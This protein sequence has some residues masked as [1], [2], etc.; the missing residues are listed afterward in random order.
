MPPEAVKPAAI[1]RNPAAFAP[2]TSLP[3]IQNAPP[4]GIFTLTKTHLKKTKHIHL[5]FA[6]F[7]GW[8]KETVPQMAGCHG[9]G[10]ESLKKTI[11]MYIGKYPK[12]PDMS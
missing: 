4:S 10:F 9:D 2:Q 1:S 5:G 12:D 6:C 7:G 3:S 11:L 8:T